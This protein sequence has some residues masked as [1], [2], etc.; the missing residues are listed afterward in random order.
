[1][2]RAAVSD[3]AAN[4]RSQRRLTRDLILDRAVALIEAE[5]PGA[6]SMRRLGSALGVEGMAIYHHFE[7]RDE[8][9]SAIGDR[10]LEPLHQLELGEDWREA[11]RRF[12]LALRGLAVAHPA[13]FQLLGLQPFDTPSALRPVE[14]LLAVLIAR[15]F[16]PAAALTIYRATV[17]YA[18][19]Y[20]L[21]EATGFTVDA[22]LPAGRRRLAA[23]PRRDFPI[24][25]GRAQELRGLGADEAYEL[26]L[27][28][29]LR[30][31][32]ASAASQH[33][34]RRA[35]RRPSSGRARS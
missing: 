23:L 10:L 14:R 7:G 16:D 18:R 22:A 9:L 35:S 24:L 20:A 6:L 34:A 12:A 15:G 17:S 5:G 13:T 31:F 1:M 4:R 32:G 33:N 21:A 30:G 28:A 8:L 29:L 26:G 11:C 19:G 27:E 25:R 3:A 2:P